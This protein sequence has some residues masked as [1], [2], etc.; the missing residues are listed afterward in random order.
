V[1]VCWCGIIFLPCSFPYSDPHFL[2]VW[3][4]SSDGPSDGDNLTVHLVT[5]DAVKTR[6]TTYQPRIVV[7]E[8]KGT[9]PPTREDLYGA[10]LFLLLLSFFVP[11]PRQLTRIFSIANGLMPKDN[12]LWDLDASTWDSFVSF[13]YTLLGRTPS[14][15]DRVE[16]GATPPKDDSHP[17]NIE[18]TFGKPSALFG[19]RRAPTKDAKEGGAKPAADA[20]KRTGPAADPEDLDDD[21]KS[22]AA[23]PAPSS[24]PAVVN[25]MR[26]AAARAEGLVDS[27]SAELSTAG[28]E[29]LKPSQIQKRTEMQGDL[30]S[31]VRL[32]AYAFIG[33]V[34]MIEL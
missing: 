6:F 19:K 28:Q 26:K 11:A 8:E 5:V 18:P 10:S 20:T 22:G 31:K 17:V 27:M 9:L 13:G 25:L 34:V 7:L 16:P 14:A 21:D 33:A 4:T 24:E 30:T 15:Q 29:L 2:A 32:I 3:W 1:H 12:R 23:A